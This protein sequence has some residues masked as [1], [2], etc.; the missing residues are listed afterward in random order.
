[1]QNMKRFI[2]LALASALVGGLVVLATSATAA[3]KMKFYVPFRQAEFNEADSGDKGP[4]PGDITSGKLPL[5]Q[6]E[7]NVGVIT[8][9]CTLITQDGKSEVCTAVARL[10]KRG[11][12]TAS[13][14][15]RPNQ[16]KSV[17]AIT[18]GTGEFRAASGQIYTD[19]TGNNRAHFTF[20]LT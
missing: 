3:T 18:G 10:K 15:D 4:T 6:G 13:F 5:F 17:V 12:I 7:N 8:F 2:A 19:F 1:M 14:S 9:T 16:E 11:T 20:V